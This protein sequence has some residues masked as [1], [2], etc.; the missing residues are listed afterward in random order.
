ML[1]TRSI[2]KQRCG[3]LEYCCLDVL[4]F[5]SILTMLF[6]AGADEVIYSREGTTQGDSLAMFFY[7]VSLLPLIRKLKDPNNVLQSWYADDSAAI[8]KLKKLEILLK[9]LIEEGPAFG[10]FPEPSKNFLIVDKQYAEEAHHI[11][12]KYSITIV[13][14]KRFLGGFIGDGNEKD[15]YLKQKEFEWVDKI[16]KL[17]F[18]AKT[19]PQCA[20]SGLTK[21]LQAEWNFS[22]RV[23][24]G[25]S[26]LFQPLENLLMEKF[27]HAILGTSSI[28]S[29]ER[30]IFC[31]PARKGGLGVSNPT[32]FA[33]ESYNTSQEA[34]TV[35]YDAI[36][37]QHGFSH[38]DHRKQMSRSR[39]KHHQIMEEKHE[40]LLGELLNELPADQIRAVK[41][42]NEGSLSA[43]LTALP[44]AA[45]NFDRSE[46]EF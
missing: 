5:S 13:E 29:M 26:Q 30:S 23:L 9:N 32:S 20:L 28:S 8:V 35:L 12:D 45:E 31:L 25:S 10:Y 27:L 40:E 42:I 14:E 2:V 43:W 39:K 21:S 41:R 19:E 46:V 34:V 7:G 22:H 18:V 4:D 1:S 6:V 11:F 24:G 36:V 44:I 17:S 33:D 16:E 38:E 37:D 3:M 15:N